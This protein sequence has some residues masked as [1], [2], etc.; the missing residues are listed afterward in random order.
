M[1]QLAN[2][3]QLKEAL[4]SFQKAFNLVSSNGPLASSA[5]GRT[6]AG[7]TL[8]F[9]GNVHTLLGDFLTYSSP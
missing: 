1:I 4:E 3:G 8:S 5:S 7:R 6:L 2:K 9:I